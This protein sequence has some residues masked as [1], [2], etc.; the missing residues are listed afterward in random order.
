MVETE[1]KV[2]EKPNEISRGEFFLKLAQIEEIHL[3]NYQ[4][5]NKLYRDALYSEHQG[6]MVRYFEDE[7]GTLSIFVRKKPKLGFGLGGED[8]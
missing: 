4:R 6:L 3:R 7:K 5:A 2:D 8:M 1:S